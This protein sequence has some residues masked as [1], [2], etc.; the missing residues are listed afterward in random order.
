T[1]PM[2]PFHSKPRYPV[3]P[4]PPAAP[5]SK[6]QTFLMGLLVVAA[7]CLPLGAAWWTVRPQEFHDHVFAYERDALAK[8]I[9]AD[10]FPVIFSEKNTELYEAG[11]GFAVTLRLNNDPENEYATTVKKVVLEK[12]ADNNFDYPERRKLVQSKAAELKQRWAEFIAPLPVPR[13][14]EIGV[15]VTDGVTEGLTNLVLFHLKDIEEKLV[16]PTDPTKILLFRLSNTYYREYRTWTVPP[17]QSAEDAAAA[18]RE[19]TTGWLLKDRGRMPHSSVSTGL[20]NML[21]INRDMRRRTIYIFSDGME[22]KPEVTADFYSALAG[23]HG[24]LDRAKWPDLDEKIS[25]WES[26][27]DLRYATVRW[28]F[29][30]HDWKYYRS[31]HRY[32]EHVLQDKCKAQDVEVIY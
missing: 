13:S 17:R 31:V 23:N 18:L 8:N 26:F 14:V 10:P 2:P 20:F 1:A 16:S 24:V 28:H 9:T 11:D 29:I 19:A 5:P 32:W 4:R 21:K 15:D 3:P 25:A 12:A 30:P 7:V 27:P 6:T 22:N